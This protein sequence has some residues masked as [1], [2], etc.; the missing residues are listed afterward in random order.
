MTVPTVTATI[1]PAP[2]DTPTPGA[3]PPE[4][5]QAVLWQLA[6]QFRVHPDLVHLVRWERVDWP[7][8]CLGIPMRDAC[9]QAVVPGYRIVVEVGGQEYEYNSTLPDA[10]PYRLLLAAG[11]DLGIEEPALQREGQKDGGCQSLVLDADG[12]AAMGP[13]DAPHVLLP[14]LEEMGRLQQWADLVARFAPFEAETPS[15]WVKFQGQGHEV[16]SPAWQRALAAW[17]RLVRMELQF[18]R[19]GASWGAA[20]AWHREMPGRPGYC[21]FLHVEMYG[22][23]YASVARCGGGDAQDLGQGWLDTAEWEQFDAWFYGRA[24]VYQQGLEF[25][26]AGTQEM[27]DSEVDALQRWAEA[28]YNRLTAEAPAPAATATPTGGYT[29][30]SISP[31]GK[32]IAEGMMEGPFLVGDDEQY[33]TQLK[34]VSTDGTVQWTVVDET[35][36]YG[37]GYTV[38]TPFHWSQDGQ[39]LYFT[40]EPVPDGCALFV[41]GSDLHRVDLTNRRVTEILPGGA[42]WLSLSPDEATLAYIRWTGEALEL[43]LRDLATGTERQMQFDVKYSDGGSIVWSPDGR[44]LMLTLASNPCD[45]ENWTQSVVRVDAATMLLTTLI[46]NDTRL[47]V[48]VEWPEARQV[49]LRNKDGNLWW[50]DTATGEVLRAAPPSNCP[51]TP[52]GGFYDVWRNEQVWPRLG[53]AVEAAIPINGT[54]AYLCCNVH[55][56]WIREKCLFVALESNFRW[57]F[58]AD[59]SGL[60]AE[61][62]FVTPTWQPPTATPG[63]PPPTP[64]PTPTQVSPPIPLTAT[65][66][67]SPSPTQPSVMPPAG[68]TTPLPTVVLMTQFSWSPSE[69]CFR[70][71]GRHGWLANLS[72]WSEKCRGL[73][74]TNETIFNGAMEQFEGGWLLWN[75]N[76]CFVLFAD[77]TWTMF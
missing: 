49:L 13:C 12:R 77:G 60:P 15:G 39:Y 2:T 27:S 7:D 37:L 21:E 45:P 75:G 16:A 47:F 61:A 35:S 69:P 55:S 48:T 76:V 72:P 6:G 65:P 29:W 67:P 26:S 40:N 4:A 10:Q 52:L 5:I 34:V 31:D 8:G 11:P 41:N 25:F 44:A 20:L 30:S 74:A 64:V 22:L 33:R 54:E 63:P 19:S 66:T 14:L 32:W 50:M 58:V 23:A 18:G 24:P 62:V 28:V 46:H 38:P 59:E 43:I 57:A 1:R 71:S 68:A 51:H 42:W 3:E 36:H 70:A 73:S 17:A 56:I 9:T 53:C